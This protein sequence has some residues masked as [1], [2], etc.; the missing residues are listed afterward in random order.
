MK[1]REESVGLSHC[2]VGLSHCGSPTTWRKRKNHRHS[3]LPEKGGGKP[4]AQYT[5]QKVRHHLAQAGMQNGTSGSQGH[6]CS[7]ARRP[8]ACET[9]PCRLLLPS[10]ANPKACRPPRPQR[11]AGNRS[12]REAAQRAEGLG[13]RKR[14]QCRKSHTG[15]VRAAALFLHSISKFYV[16]MNPNTEYELFTQEVYK[17]LMN[18]HHASIKNIQHNIKLKG[19]SCCEH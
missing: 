1:F 14:F 16:T 4:Q 11:Q 15:G 3:V 5:T 6:A 19:H 18:Y 17:Q 12:D 10:P 2:H 7:V 8:T 9:P 13:R